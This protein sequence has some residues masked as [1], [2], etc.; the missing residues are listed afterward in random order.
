MA[1]ILPNESFIFLGGDSKNAP[2]GDKEK[3]QILQFSRNN[4]E[5][6]LNK[7][8]KAIVIACNTATSAAKTELMA[9]YNV[10]IIGIEPALKPAVEAA[11]KIS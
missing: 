9:E 2:Y 11:T 4:V 8:V 1:T 10:P 5:F 6:L 7:G 3:D